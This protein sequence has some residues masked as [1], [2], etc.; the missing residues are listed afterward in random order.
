[1]TSIQRGI[2]LCIVSNIDEWYENIKLPSDLVNINAPFTLVSYLKLLLIISGEHNARPFSCSHFY[3]LL[4]NFTH[5][6]E[7]NNAK[8]MLQYF[9]PSTFHWGWGSFRNSLMYS[10]MYSTELQ[11]TLSYLSEY[12]FARVLTFVTTHQFIELTLVTI[13]KWPSWRLDLVY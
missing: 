1:M 10:I 11:H 9:K 5:W 2:I 12:K 6:I 13:P 4:T 8:N 7:M 3:V